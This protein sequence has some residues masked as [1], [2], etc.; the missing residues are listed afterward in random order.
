[1]IDLKTK[2]GEWALI[3]GAS[4]GIGKE[5]ALRFAGKGMN[6]ILIARRGKL[7]RAL[8][9][10]IKSNFKVKTLVIPIDLAKNDFMKKLL[11]KVGKKE[12]GILINNAGFGSIGE[13]TEIDMKHETA[14]VKLNCV[15]PTIL[16]HHFSKQMIKRKKGAVIF[17]GSV[18]GFYPVPYMTT[19]AATKVF[20]IYLGN[21]LW[22]ELK[23]HNVDVLTLNPGGTATE[24]QRIAKTTTGPFVRSAED[25]VNT[26]L[27]ALG[28]RHSIIDGI[29]N[30]IMVVL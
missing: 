30:R 3:T 19:Y 13:Y 11:P 26:A 27:K 1:M 6:V 10:E 18:A 23:K 24:F 29:P 8:S 21:A 20:N 2:Y 25:V 5:F 7:L 9:K 22:Y 28:R 15:V 16:T 12:I 4:S 17:L 14:M